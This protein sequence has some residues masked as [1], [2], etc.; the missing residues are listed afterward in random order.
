MRFFLSFSSR[1]AGASVRAV[2]FPDPV[3]H[4]MALRRKAPEVLFFSIIV[5]DENFTRGKLKK[6]TFLCFKRPRFMVE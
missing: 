3:F 6:F 2:L 1:C 5:S 4:T